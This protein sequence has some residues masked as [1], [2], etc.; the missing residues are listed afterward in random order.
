MI[1]LCCQC[2]QSRMIHNC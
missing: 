1:I 2:D